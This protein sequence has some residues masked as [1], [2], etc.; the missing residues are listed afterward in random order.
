MFQ[1]FCKICLNYCMQK[2]VFN[3]SWCCTAVKDI[4]EGEIN[5]SPLTSLRLCQSLCRSSLQPHGTLDLDELLLQSLP[6]YE[7]NNFKLPI[8][9]YNNDKIAKWTNKPD[10]RGL[11]KYALHVTYYKLRYISSREYAS[12]TLAT[13]LMMINDQDG[14]T[15]N[16][17]GWY[18]ESS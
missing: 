13:E 9:Q 11:K 15:L 10:F 4:C 3:H 8:A 5:M 7:D 17:W 12:H 14:P 1:V 6:G 2:N 16:F 18:R